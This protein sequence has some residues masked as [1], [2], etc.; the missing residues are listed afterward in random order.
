MNSDGLRSDTL[1]QEAR[2]LIELEQRLATS[3]FYEQT[4]TTNVMNYWVYDY[5]PRHELYVREQMNR[6][7]EKL[8][9]QGSITPYVVD[10]YTVLIDYLQK[11]DYLKPCMELE[12]EYGLQHLQRVVKNALKMTSQDNVIT[13]HI[14]SHVPPADDTLLFITGVGKCYPLLRGPAVFNHILYN[15]PQE[16]RRTP[17]VLFYPGTY[18]EQELIIINEV[19]EDNYYRAYRIVR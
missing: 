11:N 17:V 13:K 10:L 4:R 16:Y 12:T 8:A 19:N 15:L 9:R 6:I 2:R 5:N 3:D 7:V 14:A 1:E 18:T